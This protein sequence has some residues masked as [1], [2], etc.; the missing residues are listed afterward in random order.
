MSKKTLALIFG[1]LVITILLIIITFKPN[2]SKPAN[3]T[4]TPT[5]FAQTD[6][7]LHLTQISTT[8]SAL[9]SKV[10]VDVTTGINKITGVQFVISYDPSVLKNVSITAGTLFANPVILRNNIDTS[11][12]TI[13]YIIAMPPS[14]R[15]YQG[16]GT[17]ATIS[18]NIKS[19]TKK[20]TI[21]S[22]SGNTIV[23]ASGLRPSVLRTT[24]DVS[25]PIITSAH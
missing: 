19:T 4:P 10:N 23:T 5:P 12:G 22:F 17:A 21:M 7:T 16:Q 24:K 2:L 20:Q 9:P 18:F 6:L 1:L 25:I 3:V 8:N 11:K 14:G 15:P 13:S